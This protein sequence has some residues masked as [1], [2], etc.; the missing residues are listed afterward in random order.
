MRSSSTPC[1]TTTGGTLRPYS[2]VESTKVEGLR[3]GFIV[4]VAYI[5]YIAYK[6][7]NYKKVR[8]LLGG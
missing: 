8:T 7:S 2:G 4:S 1:S 5:H 6:A 3:G